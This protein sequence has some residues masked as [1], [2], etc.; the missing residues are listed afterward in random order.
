MSRHPVD[1]P[2]DHVWIDSTQSSRRPDELRSEPSEEVA[3]WLVLHR[4]SWTEHL[5]RLEKLL[6]QCI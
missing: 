1:D 5:D 6:E 3:I 4:R 2:G